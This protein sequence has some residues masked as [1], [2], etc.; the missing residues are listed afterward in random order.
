MK[1]KVSIKDIARQLGISISTVSFVVNGKAKEKRI[2][3]DL[4]K[5]VLQLVEELDYKPD[6][7]AKSFRT[8]KTNIIGFLVADISEPF[9]SGIARFIDEKASQ[10]GYKIIYSSTKNNKNKAIELLQIFQDR[11]VDGYIIALPEGLE[12][13]VKALTLN[14]K[15]VVLFDRYFPELNTDHVIINNEESTYN[16][17]K[18]LVDNGYK[19]IGFVTIDTIE[20]QMLDRL[21]GYELAIK[22][23]GLQES[24]IKIPYSNSASSI[25]EI[26]AYF[27]KEQQLDA[28]IF[29]ANYICMDGLRSIQRL[30][31]KIPEDLAVVS[32]DDF[33]LL[34]FSSPTITA[35]AQ[36]LEDI[37]ENIMSIL[38]SRLDD[39]KS[40]KGHKQVVL[41]TVLNVRKSSLAQS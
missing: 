25:K 39:Q 19:H 11:H 37:A 16:A 5:K 40:E 41:P 36:P 15:P 1:K 35:I 28:V 6:A 24:I 33:E 22:T 29:A 9:F 23:E 21:K 17:T 31:L 18:H 26:S 10:K 12:D 20:Q 3:D 7:L 30:D 13:E 2:S 38:L 34:E 32:F 27:Q 14:Q 4:T 8:G